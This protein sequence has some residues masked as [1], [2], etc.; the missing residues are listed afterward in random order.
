MERRNELDFSLN[1]E[2]GF[3][4]DRGNGNDNGLSC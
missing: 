4:E 3:N 2:N 1:F